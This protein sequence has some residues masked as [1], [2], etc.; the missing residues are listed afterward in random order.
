MKEAFIKW[1]NTKFAWEWF[2]NGGIME[3]HIW[4]AFQAG[5]ESK[6]TDD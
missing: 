5:W 2:E 4:E 6:Y 3:K 1:W